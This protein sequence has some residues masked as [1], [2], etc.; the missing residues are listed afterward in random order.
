V[1]DIRSLQLRVIPHFVAFPL[2]SSKGQD[3]ERSRLCVTW[4]RAAPT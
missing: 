4:W 2:R 3:F 1:R